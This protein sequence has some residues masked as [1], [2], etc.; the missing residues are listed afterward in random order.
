MAGFVLVPAAKND[1][2]EIIEYI[3][4]DSPDAASKVLDRFEE[5]LE[6]L[7][8]N[9]EMGHYREDLTGRPIRF[10]PVYSYLIIYMADTHPLQVV[11][12]LSGTR[13]IERILN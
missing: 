1:L 8:E 4:D 3:A 6:L 9:P 12:V 10:F 11:R 5:A 13:D 7:V 2:L